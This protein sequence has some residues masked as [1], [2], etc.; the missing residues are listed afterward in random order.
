MDSINMNLQKLF[1]IVKK[2]S[3]LFLII[4]TGVFSGCKKTPE[5]DTFVENSVEKIIDFIIKSF[6]IVF[7]A[8][9]IFI[10]LLVLCRIIINRRK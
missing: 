7:L 2:Q 4:L 8:I 6:P 10:V 1:A 5:P 9:I 3:L